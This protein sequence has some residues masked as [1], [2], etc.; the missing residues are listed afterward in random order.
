VAKNLFFPKGWRFIEKFGLL[1]CKDCKRFF[2][3][4]ETSY[5]DEQDYSRLFVYT[6]GCECGR[7]CSVEAWNEETL[8]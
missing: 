6:G 2:Q 1:P 8:R 7:V 3:I 5:R 4:G